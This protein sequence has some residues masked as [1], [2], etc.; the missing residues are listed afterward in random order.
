MVKP[1]QTN[2]HKPY[3]NRK[4]MIKFKNSYYGLFQELLYMLVI[5]MKRKCMNN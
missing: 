1:S 4:V 2:K 5:N 3:R